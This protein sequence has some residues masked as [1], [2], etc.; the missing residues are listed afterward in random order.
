MIE[1]QAEFPY[2]DFPRLTHFGFESG[3]P[4]SYPPEHRH[5]GFEFFYFSE[6]S[7]N[8]RL[9][10]KTKPLAVK[11]H[12]LLVIAPGAEHSFITQAHHLSYYWLGFQTGKRVRRAK[13]STLLRRE[14]LPGELMPAAGF[15]SAMDQHLQELDKNFDS[16][17]SGDSFVLVPASPRL[18]L[19]FSDLREELTRKESYAREIIYHRI[20]ELLTRVSRLLKRGVLENAEPG[21][22]DAVKAFLTERHASPPS[23]KELASVFKVHPAYLSRIFKT[24]TGETI[25][26][27]VN[28]CRMTSA[29]EMLF[30][31]TSVGE[32]ARALG[33]ASLEYFSARF[34]K[35]WGKPP[36][37]F[38]PQP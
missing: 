3:A 24:Q 30:R 26:D 27:F 33:F 2:E 14:I 13:R 11:A 34:K 10:E 5:F 25:G 35:W 6:G 31:G 7:G 1:F 36:S 29:K 8:V 18:G 17:K 4:T 22:I 38:R 19:I 32:T 21:R 28:E 15:A 12:D 37:S 20:L 9:A 23:L 16:K